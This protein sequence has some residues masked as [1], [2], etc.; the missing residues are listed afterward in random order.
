MSQRLYV[1]FS[2]R[3]ELRDAP[4]HPIFEGL[5]GAVTASPA[6]GAHKWCNRRSF[7]QIV[8]TFCIT[9]SKDGTG[10]DQRSLSYPIN[11]YPKRFIPNVLGFFAA[12]CLFL[13]SFFAYSWYERRKAGSTMAESIQ[14]KDWLEIEDT[15][16]R[17]SY[18]EYT[19][20]RWL[21]Q[22]PFALIPPST[23]FAQQGRKVP[24]PEA[25]QDFG[26]VKVPE[27]QISH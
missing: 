8:P 13:G 9:V 26:W 2:L 11:F 20:E 7:H 24:S 5:M 15:L 10:R 27:S 4:I 21:W 12:V 18:W 23:D 6:L 1:G 19:L 3:M 22:A 16:R 17:N 14:K 25:L